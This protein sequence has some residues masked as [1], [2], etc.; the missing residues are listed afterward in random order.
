M[1]RPSQTP[2]LN[3]SSVGNEAEADIM[4]PINPHGDRPR[5]SKANQ[6]T[7]K[8]AHHTS[9]DSAKPLTLPYNRSTS[10]DN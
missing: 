9:L 1:Y 10:P 6:A 5:G 2:H 7:N 3:L 4:E 8:E